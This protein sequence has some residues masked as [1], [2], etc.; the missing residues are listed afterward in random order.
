MI[1]FRFRWVCAVSTKSNNESESSGFIQFR[2]WTF[3]TVRLIRQK[4]FDGSLVHV[5]PQLTS[6]G[7][8]AHLSY[9]QVE[10]AREADLGYVSGIDRNGA[11]YA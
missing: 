7:V 11:S 9:S 3:R 4:S 2:N 1:S 10:I 5:C 8:Q 6:P